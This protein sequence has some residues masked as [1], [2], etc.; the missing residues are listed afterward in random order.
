MHLASLTATVFNGYTKKIMKRNP[1]ILGAS[2]VEF[3]RVLLILAAA[4]SMLSHTG[5]PLTLAILRTLAVGSFV[6]PA[7]L[8]LVWADD[9]FVYFSYL[10]IPLKIGELFINVLNIASLLSGGASLDS[11]LSVK[12]FQALMG[13]LLVMLMDIF[14]V[15]VILVLLKKPKV[16]EQPVITIE[17]VE[18]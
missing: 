17:R 6:F 11:A 18:L 9:R 16:P 1:V 5:N 8:A 13:S 15:T 12:P 2:I 4:R 7:L 10:F 14:I 3:L